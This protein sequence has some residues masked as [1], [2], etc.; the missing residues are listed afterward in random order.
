LRCCIAHFQAT[1]DGAEPVYE[2]PGFRHV[3]S[4]SARASSRRR[5]RISRACASA[6]GAKT[7]GALS[8]YVRDPDGNVIELTTS[9]R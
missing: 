5:R 2:S 1:T 9:E 6:S 7:T 4:W 3:A 8:L